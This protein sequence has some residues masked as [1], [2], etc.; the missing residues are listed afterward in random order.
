MGLIEGLR[1]GVEGLGASPVEE[2]DIGSVVGIGGL[3]VAPVE[4]VAI[5]FIVGADVGRVRTGLVGV[6]PGRVVGLGVVLVEGGG[7]G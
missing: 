3:G 7:I 1:I 5:G 4:G 2:L 6:A